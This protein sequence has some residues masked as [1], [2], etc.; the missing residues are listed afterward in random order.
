MARPNAGGYEQDAG[1]ASLTDLWREV[2]T[3][4][5]RVSSQSVAA[6]E[7]ELPTIDS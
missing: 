2:H 4:L 5:G 7:E 3:I 6:E 1:F